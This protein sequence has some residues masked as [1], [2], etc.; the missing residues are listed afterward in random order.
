[1][2]Q[3]V[4]PELNLIYSN[5]YLPDAVPELWLSL[6]TFSQNYKIKSA[7]VTCI[8]TED[9]SNVVHYDGVRVSEINSEIH[10]SGI[11]GADSA[12]DTFSRQF[13]RRFHLT[14]FLYH[15]LTLSTLFECPFLDSTSILANRCT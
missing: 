1:M 12:V 3:L 7:V 2:R 11:R 5:D 8:Y 4:I 9:G 14:Y 13:E 6:T 15:Q 10:Y